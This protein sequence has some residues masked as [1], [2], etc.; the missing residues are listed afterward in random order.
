MKIKLLHGRIIFAFLIVSS[1]VLQIIAVSLKVW[2]S[3]N[4]WYWDDTVSEID[5]EAGSRTDYGS[6]GGGLMIVSIIIHIFMLIFMIFTIPSDRP[7]QATFMMFRSS[8]LAL[9]PIIKTA[10]CIGIMSIVACGSTSP[11]YSILGV[12]LGMLVFACVIGFVVAYKMKKKIQYILSTN[13]VGRC[14]C[15]VPY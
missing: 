11:G 10:L 5:E 7:V 2:D 12:S 9:F 8:F 6:L 14:T 3:E 4:I 15:C 13:P 1:L